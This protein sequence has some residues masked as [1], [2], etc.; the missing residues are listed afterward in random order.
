VNAAAFHAQ[1]RQ[2]PMGTA[3]GL[4][5]PD[6]M[7]NSGTFSGYVLLPTGFVNGDIRWDKGHITHASGVAATEEEVAASG[8]P[9]AIPGFIDT[10]VHGAQG[11]DFMDDTPDAALAVAQAHARYGT[12]ALLATTLSAPAADLL[13]MFKATA[14]SLTPAIRPAARVLGVHLEGPFI[15]EA[16]LGAQPNA[17]RA[18]TLQEIQALHDLLPIRV[19][20]LA[21]EVTDN[22]RLI[23]PL[24]AMGMR[25]QI[26]HSNA[27][28]EQA[29]E[30][31]AQGAS[32][33][34]HVFN[35]MSALHHRAPGVV[36]AAL[37]HAKHG[38]IICDLQHV[39]PGAIRVALRCIDGL[40]CVT[41]AT[42]ATGMPDGEHHLGEQRIQKCMGA[43]RLADGT[44]AGSVLTMDQAF[45]NLVQSLGLTRAQAS[46]LTSTRAAD[47]LGE[48]DIGRLQVGAAADVV[49]LNA[50]LHVQQVY[51]Q[52]QAVSS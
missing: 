37:A 12:T 11:V 27:T 2:F 15:N 8:Q 52:G 43:V 23:P 28:Y 35:A 29:S 22:H 47:Y 33:V 50:D 20:T 48:S 36:G 16:R 13:R 19:I 24:L 44:L 32:G 1:T 34:T 17:L 45:R 9:F 10:H 26:G 42:S 46:A 25:V 14:A 38:E 18:A 40:F 4:S 5:Y 21:P 3:L 49:V 39:H 7:L 31:I 41:D 30:A 51:T 6:L